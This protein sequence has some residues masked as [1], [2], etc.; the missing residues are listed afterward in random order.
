[1]GT[2]QTTSEMGNL[3][4]VVLGGRANQS[5]A[6]RHNTNYNLFKNVQPFYYWF[7]VTF[8]S[9]LDSWVFGFGDTWHTYGAANLQFFAWAV[10]PGDVGASPVPLPATL[11]FLA[12]ALGGLSFMRRRSK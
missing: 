2:N 12:P 4:Y 10:H 7:D 6:S 11:F 9:N 5:V 1:M 3:F 8:H